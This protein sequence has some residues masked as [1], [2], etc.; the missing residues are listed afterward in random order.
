MSGVSPIQLSIGESIV[1]ENLIV[2]REYGVDDPI[3]PIQRSQILIEFRKQLLAKVDLG[4]VGDCR[5]IY[6]RRSRNLYRPLQNE[7]QVAQALH[8]NGFISIYPESYN[9]DTFMKII[10]NTE[11]VVAESGAAIT[12]L[13]FARPG[14]KFLEILPAIALVDFWENF[15]GIFGIEY[16]VIQGKTKRLGPKGYAYDG[17]RISLKELNGKISAW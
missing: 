4:E 16:S 2:V 1:V 9:L 11:Y 5:K 10:Q 6:L 17:Y 12:N 7:D 15:V 3:D 8:N 14:T 13:M